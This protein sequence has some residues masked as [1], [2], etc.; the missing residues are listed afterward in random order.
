MLLYNNLYMINNVTN[1]TSSTSK[2]ICSS[3]NEVMTANAPHT[4]VGQQ[5]KS[6]QKNTVVPVCE[7]CRKKKKGKKAIVSSLIG[8]S[9]AVISLG[10]IY[11]YKVG[12]T[13]RTA[14]GFDGIS[15]IK[16]SVNIQIKNLDKVNIDIETA[17]IS[18][19]P[20]SEQSPVDNIEDFNRFLSENQSATSAR[21]ESILSVPTSQLH[22]Q[23]NSSELSPKSVQ[24]VEG[25]AHFFKETNK[26]SKILIEGF[27]C[28]LG[29]NQVNNAISQQRAEALKNAFISNGVDPN[30]LEV[31]WYGESKNSEFKFP[32]MSDYRRALVSF[33]K[34]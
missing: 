26:K 13:P 10:T 33:Q 16:D 19:I 22:F 23:L 28:N 15:T 21:E 8:A 34:K 27:A 18:S 31:R 2:Q 17:T 24:M 14:Q 12:E 30:H 9:I 1:Q 5:E 20:T 11:L 25:I 32:H 3:C 4:Q 7:K 29:D 6:K